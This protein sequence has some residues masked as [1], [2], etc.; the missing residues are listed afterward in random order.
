MVALAKET[1]P[2]PRGRRVGAALAR[3]PRRGA[4]GR[5]TA[6]LAGFAKQSFCCYV[7]DCWARR[8]LLAFL[9]A[10]EPLGLRV[11]E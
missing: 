6:S 7:P 5:V 11:V 4:L 3:A 1:Q 9:T 10:Q 8:T 2:D